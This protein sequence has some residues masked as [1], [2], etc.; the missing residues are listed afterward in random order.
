MAASDDQRK[1]QQLERSATLLAE[2]QGQLAAAY[3]E[4]VENETAAQQASTTL[5]QQGEGL[6]SARNNFQIVES[7]LTG[8][9]RAMREMHC[10]SN[11]RTFALAAM[12]VLLLATL[13]VVIYFAFIKKH[14][15]H[16]HS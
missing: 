16:G 3:R 8:S 7:N 15:H 10:L 14:E 12:V 6:R 9:Q 1:T 2:S 11:S 5:Q 13:V 4:A